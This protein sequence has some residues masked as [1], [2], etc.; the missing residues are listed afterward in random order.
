NQI[1]PVATGGFAAIVLSEVID[2]VLIAQQPMVKGLVKFAGAAAVF[3]WGK[4]IPFR[5]D[6]GKNIFAGLLIFD[7]LRDVT[8][9]STWASQVANAISGAIPVG[10]LGDQRG[11]DVVA[12][13][14]QVARNYSQVSRGGW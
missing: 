10:G 5:G 4:Q 11:R 1:L 13:A 2:G 3:T 14:S 6:V 9:I 7:A 8:P 12:Q